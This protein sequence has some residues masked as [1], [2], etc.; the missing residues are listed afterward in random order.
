MSNYSI[1]TLPFVVAITIVGC[2]GGSSDNTVVTSNNPTTAI[3]A[4]NQQLVAAEVSANALKFTGNTLGSIAD[5]AL[6]V[7]TESANA[8]VIPNMRLIVVNLRD[9][10][11][12]KAQPLTPQV[13]AVAVEMSEN[14]FAG[15][16]MKTSFDDKNANTEWDVNETGTVSFSNCVMQ[17]GSVING[18]VK[19]EFLLEN[20]TTTTDRFSFT[21]FKVSFMSLTSE[22]VSGTATYTKTTTASLQNATLKSADHFVTQALKVKMMVGSGGQSESFI[23]DE[24]VTFSQSSPN[25]TLQTI[26]GTG[27]INSDNTNINGSVKFDITTPIEVTSSQPTT[28]NAGQMTI[29][30]SGGTALYVTF[31]MPDTGSVTMQLT[32]DGTSVGTPKIVPVASILTTFAG[33]TVAN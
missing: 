33:G 2:G 14:C 25:L 27:S 17:D 1:K 9:L 26:T 8:E 6:S 24:D 23:L 13:V 10:M 19:D 15:G 28:A 18:S 20:P 5:A 30:G 29:S 16:T 3:S 32:K 22:L 21:N 7:A 31:A 12:N 4:A 11:R